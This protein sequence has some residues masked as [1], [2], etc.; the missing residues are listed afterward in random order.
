MHDCI[1]IFRYIHLFANSTSLDKIFHM[2]D[3]QFFLNPSSYFP[4]SPNSIYELD[5]ILTVRDIQIKR[6]CPYQWIVAITGELTKLE[7]RKKTEAKI[8]YYEGMPR[9]D[10]RRWEWSRPPAHR[11][12]TWW[13]SLCSTHPWHSS[14]RVDLSIVTRRN[15]TIGKS[16]STD[17]ATCSLC[18]GT[19]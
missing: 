12:T 8:E 5:R 13:I 4:Y 7:R 15:H 9:V 17:P 19:G 16:T 14:S 10:R 6:R 3:D 1:Q 18:R 2:Q 11:K